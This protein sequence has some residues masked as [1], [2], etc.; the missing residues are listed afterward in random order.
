M[1]LTQ[2]RINA[3]LDYCKRLDY[4]FCNLILSVKVSKIL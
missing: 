2:L 4:C 1:T 3:T